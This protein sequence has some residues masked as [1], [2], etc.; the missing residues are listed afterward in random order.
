MQTM[1][2]HVLS[3]WAAQGTDHLADM[4]AQQIACP[5]EGSHGKKIILVW[6]KYDQKKCELI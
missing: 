3:Q 4:F 1:R 6:S 2:W 5:L